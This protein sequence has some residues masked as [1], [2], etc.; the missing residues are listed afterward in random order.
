[1][2]L[3]ELYKVIIYDLKLVIRYEIQTIRQLLGAVPPDPTSVFSFYLQSEPPSKKSGYGPAYI[4][5]D[6]GVSIY[7]QM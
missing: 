2:E 1:L 3:L 7:K 6:V 4:D 5:V